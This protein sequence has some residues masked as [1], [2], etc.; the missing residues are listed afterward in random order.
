MKRKMS[1]LK[2]KTKFKKPK[3]KK[4]IIR[5]DGILQ[6]YNVT[7]NDL[8]EHRPLKKLFYSVQP[9]KGGGVALLGKGKSTYKKGFEK[10]KKIKENPPKEIVKFI[11]DSFIKGFKEKFGETELNKITDFVIP[12]VTKGKTVENTLN[13]Q[14]AEYMANKLGIK[15]HSDFFG[16]KHFEMKKYTNAEKVVA[17]QEFMQDAIIDFSKVGNYLVLVDDMMTTG[18][19]NKEIRRKVEQAGKRFNSMIIFKNG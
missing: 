3:T 11:G 19:T 5:K 12:P 16:E 14:V 9:S 4:L 1:K 15:V 6:N 8:K 7:V 13:F 17:F 18:T 10:I 2:P